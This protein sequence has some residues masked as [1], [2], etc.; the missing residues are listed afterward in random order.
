MTLPPPPRLRR[1]TSGLGIYDEASSLLAELT[2]AGRLSPEVRE[3]LALLWLDSDE[4]QHAGELAREG[5]G[6]MRA[7][8]YKAGYQ[9]AEDEFEEGNYQK[10]GA[11]LEAIRG[12]QTTDAAFHDLLG[13]V[14]YVLDNPKKASVELQLAVQL[15]PANPDHYFRLGMIFLKHR[16]TDPAILI[17]Q[18]ALKTLPDAPNLWVGLGMTTTSP[19][20]SMMPRALCARRWSLIR[21]MRLPTRP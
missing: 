19:T 2:R 4:P 7:R 16:T 9:R 1:L 21:M 20:D 6:E 15:E 8:C 12:L 3:Q 11:V 13:T 18:S 10:A 5:G 17:F 14:Y